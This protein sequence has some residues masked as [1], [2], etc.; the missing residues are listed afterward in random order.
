MTDMV[1]V[2]ARSGAENGSADCLGTTGVPHEYF[3]HTGTDQEGARQQAQRRPSQQEGRGHRHDTEAR[4]SGQLFPAATSESV[5][6]PNTRPESCAK[7]LPTKLIV[8]TRSTKVEK[9]RPVV[10]L[11]LKFVG[12]VRVAAD[13][14]ILCTST[15]PT[16]HLY[17]FRGEGQ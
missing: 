5:D 3:A 10:C 7:T 14:K 15:A 6:L 2:E 9:A 8:S 11:N 12:Q 1:D 16:S 4:A 17:E 13:R